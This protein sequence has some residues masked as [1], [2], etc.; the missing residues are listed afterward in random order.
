MFLNDG[1][2][3][4][5]PYSEISLEEANYLMEHHDGEAYCDADKRMVV[6]IE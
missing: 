5:I 1:R 2:L 3:I 4:E 6:M